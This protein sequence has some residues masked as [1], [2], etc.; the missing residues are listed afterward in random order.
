MTFKTGISG[1]LD[2]WL[3]ASHDFH[4]RRPA[5]INH[6]WR[7]RLSRRLR[8]L[9]AMLLPAVLCLK[10]CHVDLNLALKLEKFSESA[11]LTSWQ[12]AVPEITLVPI[13]LP[14]LPP[15]SGSLKS[16]KTYWYGGTTSQSDTLTKHPLRRHMMYQL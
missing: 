8:R 12:T 3:S 15:Q 10:S 16:S 9:S 6:G 7:G 4:G 2:G 11:E 14:P 1:G 5:Y 13:L